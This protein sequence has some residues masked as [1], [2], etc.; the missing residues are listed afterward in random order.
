MK[1]GAEQITPNPAQT[2]Q[3]GQ[4]GGTDRP[5][6]PHSSRKTETQSVFNG[7]VF[8]SAGRAAARRLP[9]RE[10]DTASDVQTEQRTGQRWAP[11]LTVTS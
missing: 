7:V 5:A 3:T 9:T 8:M 1:T 4:T 2:G 6:G 10:A 11:V